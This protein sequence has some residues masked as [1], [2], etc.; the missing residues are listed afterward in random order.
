MDSVEADFG[1]W[2]EYAYQTGIH[3]AVIS[4][5]SVRRE[6]FYSLETTVEGKWF[7]TPRGWE[8]LSRLMDVYEA[9]GK[10]VDRD[11]VAQY[12]RQ[13][14]IAKDFAN[15]LDLYHKYRSDDRIGKVLEG[16]PGR[17]ADGPGRE[18]GL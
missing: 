3:P 2:K 13:P 5:L 9:Q 15:Y 1:V 16:G 17:G 14:K 10:T 12:I 7:A 4:Y 6:Y 8:D 11:V 18:G